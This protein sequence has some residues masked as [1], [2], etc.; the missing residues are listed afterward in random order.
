MYKAIAAC[1][2]GKFTVLLQARLCALF[3]NFKNIPS[4]GCGSSLFLFLA[5][6]TGLCL[7]PWQ[8]VARLILNL[9]PCHQGFVPSL[10]LFPG[11]PW[12]LVASLFLNLCPCHQGFVPSLILFPCVPP[13]SYR[14]GMKVVLH[15]K[16]NWLDSW[17]W[18]CASQTSFGKSP[19]VDPAL[20]IQWVSL[21]LWK[22]MSQACSFRLWNLSWKLEL[23][24]HMVKI[25]HISSCI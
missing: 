6:T 10:I 23:E 12:Q 17:G 25:M 24:T 16:G 5:A 19:S 7:C 4:L 11:G 2:A 3:F 8:L 14:L 15:N 18:Y 20:Q 22:A 13:S 9:C 1:I 21:P